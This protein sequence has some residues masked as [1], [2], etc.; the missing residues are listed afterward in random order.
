MKQNNDI[1]N[2]LFME[3]TQKGNQLYLECNAELKVL[4][5][6]I[7]VELMRKKPHNIV[8]IEHND[9]GRL[10]TCVSTWNQHME[11]EQPVN[12]HNK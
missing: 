4:M 3:N 2:I 10:N 11:T 8:R 12:D 9:S 6:T 7:S 1:I 5:E